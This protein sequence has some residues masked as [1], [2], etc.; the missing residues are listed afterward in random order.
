[1]LGE[2]GE[3]DGGALRDQGGDSGEITRGAAPPLF[4]FPEGP[5][6]PARPSCRAEQRAERGRARASP[7]PKR[8]DATDAPRVSPHPEVADIVTREGKCDVAA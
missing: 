4:F 3:G 1:M 2:P 5:T 8:P 6:N 7:R